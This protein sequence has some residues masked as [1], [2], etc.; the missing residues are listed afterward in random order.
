MF[1]F[2]ESATEKTDY[3]VGSDWASLKKT[4]KDYKKSKE[5][6]NVLR[7]RQYANKIKNLQK[8][9]GLHESRFTEL[10]PYP[11]SLYK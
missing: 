9:L 2:E 5:N 11:E 7:M 3:I 8:K 10:D 6:F 1:K 4:W